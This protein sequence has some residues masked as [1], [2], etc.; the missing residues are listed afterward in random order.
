NYLLW[1]FSAPPADM[2]ASG[3]RAFVNAV[4][5]IRRF[6]GARPLVR[7]TSSAREWALRYATT[8]RFLGDDYRRVATESKRDAFTRHPDWI[9]EPARAQ[10]VD[11]FVAAQ[12]EQERKSN[13]DVM[14]LLHP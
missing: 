9:P 8:P 6:D 5:Y 10:G 7:V 3:R 11:A 4:A 13:A 1:G 14:T 2:T 12:V